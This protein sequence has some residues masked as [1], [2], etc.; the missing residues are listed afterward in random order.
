V[1]GSLQTVSQNKKTI[2]NSAPQNEF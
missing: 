1:E 2:N